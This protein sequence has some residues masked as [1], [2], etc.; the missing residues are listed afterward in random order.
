MDTTIDLSSIHLIL[1]PSNV[2]IQC[3]YEKLTIIQT[4][5]NRKIIE[6]IVL[7]RNQTEIEIKKKDTCTDPETQ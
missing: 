1:Y 4:E 2:M 6:I 7:V 3:L 5:S